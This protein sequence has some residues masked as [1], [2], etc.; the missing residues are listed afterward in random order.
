MSAAHTVLRRGLTALAMLALAGTIVATASGAQFRG[1]YA[2][3]S[4][5]LTY[6]SSVTTNKARLADGT[7]GTL[8][9][10]LKAT[11]RSKKAGAASGISSPEVAN[12]FICSP[13]CPTFAAG[14]VVTFTQTL[15]PDGS[16]APTSC[17]ATKTL[18]TATRGT[19]YVTSGKTGRATLVFK[20]SDA[21]GANDLYAAVR[22]SCALPTLYPVD[23]Y[24][25]T[26]F[27]TKSIPT[28]RLGAKTITLTFANALKPPTYPWPATGT[29]KV[30]A[31][32]ILDRKS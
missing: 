14:G 29:T 28:S 20:V 7:T 5:V 9:T 16:G 4:I 15:T 12:Q 17:K 22:G 11:L 13:G 21:K 24:D 18:P 26:A 27:G 8:K 10:T 6:S 3:R 25:Y 32:V 31:T 30:T 23:S 2:V 1:T 19:V